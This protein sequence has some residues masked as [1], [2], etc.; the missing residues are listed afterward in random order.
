MQ[1]I[2]KVRRAEQTDRVRLKEIV[3]LSFPR[4]FRFFAHHSLNSPEGKTLICEYDGDRVGFTKLTDFDIDKLRYG[5]ILWLAV[6]PDYRRK[7]VASTLVQASMENLKQEK[8]ERVFASVQRRNKASLAT[9]SKA[10][11]ERVGFRGLWRIFGWR[12]LVFYHS[13]WYVPGEVVLMHA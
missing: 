12:I 9:L 4:F 1:T 3:D 2:L 8:T 13:I 5:C 6:H 10:E 11:F 7:G